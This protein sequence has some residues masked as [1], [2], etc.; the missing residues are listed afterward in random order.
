MIAH[1]HGTLS[2]GDKDPAREEAFPS[3]K[4][5][6]KGH[7][8]HPD[9]YLIDETLRMPLTT[10]PYRCI[11]VRLSG[12]RLVVISPTRKF[13]EHKQRIDALGQVVAIVEP[14]LFHNLFTRTAKQLYPDAQ[15]FGVK[16]LLKKFPQAGW[17]AALSPET[18]PFQ[19]ELPIFAVKGMPK[20]DEH[21]FL[22]KAARILIT[23][24]L[25]FHIEDP[26]GAGGWLLYHIFGTYRRFGVSRL[27][28]LFIKDK[29][30][31]RSS[32]AEILALDFD[33]LLMNHGTPLVS[34]GKAA[35]RA[36][37]AE[38]GP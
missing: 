24:D 21:V 1:R 23:T 9:L 34:G 7:H 26:K 12:N 37:L 38:R 2:R 16:G 11:V 19:E 10:L 20:V 4:P 14:N 15:L 29:A 33:G 35:L 5:F 30:A 32:L 13:A 28:T 25:C 18:W 6:H 22:F 17:D 27:F 31:C 8:M 3:Q 36:A